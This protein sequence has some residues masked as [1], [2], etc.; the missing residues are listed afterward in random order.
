MAPV[1]RNR[2]RSIHP[3]VLAS[4]HH[5]TPVAACTAHAC[6]TPHHQH[7][8]SIAV[9][10]PV[11]GGIS[12]SDDQTFRP[13]DRWPWTWSRSRSTGCR[14]PGA[15]IHIALAHR[16]ACCS[17]AERLI[18]MN[19]Y[20]ELAIS[21]VDRRPAATAVVR[22]QGERSDETTTPKV[23]QVAAFSTSY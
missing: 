23:D 9:A 18:R 11:R 5:S 3:S 12:P 22:T 6:H 15:C 21:V 7:A 10:V 17:A 1:Q 19:W 8:D 20:G 16:P 2:D 13:I 14:V 4:P